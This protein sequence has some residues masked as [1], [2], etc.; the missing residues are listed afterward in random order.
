MAILHYNTF[1]MQ[2]G[3]VQVCYYIFVDLLLSTKQ[4]HAYKACGSVRQRVINY[5]SKLTP[6]AI[7]F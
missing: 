1:C 6:N 7:H 5:K 3:F 2:L 4:L